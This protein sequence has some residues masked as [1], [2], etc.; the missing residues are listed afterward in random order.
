MAK[1]VST[2]GGSKLGA[3]N[4]LGAKHK[5]DFKI[6]ISRNVE[7]MAYVYICL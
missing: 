6:I 4:E 1:I 3:P 2:T 5:K 7:Q